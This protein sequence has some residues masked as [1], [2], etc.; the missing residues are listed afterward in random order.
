MAAV[1]E[2][3][4]GVRDVVPAWQG[5]PG[6]EI[7]VGVVGVTGRVSGGWCGTWL[8]PLPEPAALRT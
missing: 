3:P 6:T 5:V 8:T 1:R 7:A 2:D 4:D